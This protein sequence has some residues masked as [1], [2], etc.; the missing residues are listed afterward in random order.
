VVEAIEAAA[1]A[2]TETAI[3]VF[4]NIQNLIIEYFEKRLS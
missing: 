2:V 4:R 1:V 3:S